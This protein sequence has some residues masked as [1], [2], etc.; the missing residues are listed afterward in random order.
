MALFPSPN[1][2]V[3]FL[4]MIGSYTYVSPMKNIRGGMGWEVWKR[5]LI[6]V[7]WKKREWN[8]E[9]CLEI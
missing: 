6:K 9:L 5:K 4:Y 1:R 8:G 3:I 2:K 7:V